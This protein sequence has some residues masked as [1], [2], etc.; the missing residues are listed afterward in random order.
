MFV[1]EN[2]CSFNR[3]FL[4]RHLYAHGLG[5]V[6]D[7]ALYMGVSMIDNEYIKLQS[8]IESTPGSVSAKDNLVELSKFY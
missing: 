1:K 3:D 7:M 2:I 8:L 5:F 6:Q 4:G